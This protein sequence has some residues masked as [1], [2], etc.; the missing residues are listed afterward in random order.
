MHNLGI[1]CYRRNFITCVQSKDLVLCNVKLLSALVGASRRAY[2][3]ISKLL[4]AGLFYFLL[5]SLELIPHWIFGF[6][7]SYLT[8][9]ASC[10]LISAEKKS[11]FLPVWG[12]STASRE[13]FS[14]TVPLTTSLPYS[15]LLG[16]SAGTF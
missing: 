2:R 14:I 15:H 16:L 11:S 1:V 8:H 3:G 7:Y 5:P 10:H 12:P 13:S 4:T 6:L 9:F